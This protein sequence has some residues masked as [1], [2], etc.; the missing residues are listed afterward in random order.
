M[1][2]DEKTRYKIC[3]LLSDTVV[4]KIYFYT[5]LHTTVPIFSMMFQ[6]ETFDLITNAGV[7]APRPL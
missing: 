6:I 4:C 3:P 5:I 2:E 1:S 7:Q